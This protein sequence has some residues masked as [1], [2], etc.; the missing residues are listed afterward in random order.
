[1]KNKPRQEEVGDDGENGDAGREQSP[2]E[3]GVLIREYP[4]TLRVRRDSGEQREKK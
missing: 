4:G 2:A 1:M 3:G